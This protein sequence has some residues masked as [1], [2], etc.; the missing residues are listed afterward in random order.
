MG[1]WEEATQQKHDG[2]TR[3]TT[4]GRKAQEEMD[5]EEPKEGSWEEANLYHWARVHHRRFSHR[6]VLRADCRMRDRFHVDTTVNC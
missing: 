6:T 3:T 5:R 4:E 1:S 2:H